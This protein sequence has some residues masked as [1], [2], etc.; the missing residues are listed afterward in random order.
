M[1]QNIH[2]FQHSHFL[3]FNT[4][5]EEKV[6]NPWLG[7]IA[8]F[9]AECRRTEQ[10]PWANTGLRPMTFAAR[11]Y[12]EQ[13]EFQAALEANGDWDSDIEDPINQSM[14]VDPDDVFVDYDEWNDDFDY[15]LCA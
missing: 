10:K 15:R 3:G 11:L 7:F 5:Q 8:D 13:Q 12:H 2:S 4:D 6:V 1:L 9:F 14:F